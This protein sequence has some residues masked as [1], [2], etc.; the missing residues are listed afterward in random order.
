[1]FLYYALIGLS[2]QIVYIRVYAVNMLC[3]IARKNPEAMLEVSEKISALAD[4]NYWEIKTQCLEFAA[5]IL[6]MFKEHSVLLAVKDDIKGGNQAQKT[7]SPP[8]NASK[9]H[10]DLNLNVDKS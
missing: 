8:N 7:S 5:I 4:E 2:N 9:P 3:S 10:S 6:S 1:M